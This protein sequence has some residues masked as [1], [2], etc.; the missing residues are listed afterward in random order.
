MAAN[1]LPPIADR[2]HSDVLEVVRRQMRQN[3]RIDL[4]PRKSASYWPRPRCEATRRHPSPRLTWLAQIFASS[5]NLSTTQDALVTPPQLP[6]GWSARG[7]DLGLGPADDR[8]LGD[9]GQP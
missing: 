6:V 1:E 8:H 4:I 3:S 5:A 9:P 2:A 7:D